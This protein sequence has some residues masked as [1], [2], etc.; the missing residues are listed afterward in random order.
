MCVQLKVVWQWSI[1]WRFMVLLRVEYAH[2]LCARRMC[3]WFVRRVGQVFRLRMG[4][5]RGVGA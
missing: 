1:A 4:V 2:A 3:S 5:W